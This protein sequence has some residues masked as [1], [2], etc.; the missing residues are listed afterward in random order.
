[1]TEQELQWADL[2]RAGNRG[3]TLAY[4][5]LLAALAPAM[6][7]FARSNFTRAGLSGDDVEDVVQETLLALHLKRHTWDEGQPLLPWVR[8]I[9][10]NKVIDHLRRK[11]SR[12][13][14]A[15]DDIGDTLVDPAA[16]DAEQTAELSSAVAHLKDRDR[17]IV[18]AMSLE[19]ASARDLAQKLGMSE[20]AVRVALHRA[21]KTL[22]R[23]L[24]SKPA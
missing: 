22:A 4:N 13:H 7:R 17:Q 10:R 5:R 15:I 11:G 1:M 3:D 23:A 16:Q 6:R 18:A 19:G 20:G 9:A 21:L 12:V 24:G 8:A 14:I 2:M